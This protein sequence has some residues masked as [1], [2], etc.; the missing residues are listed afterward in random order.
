LGEGQ[1]EALFVGGQL[2]DTE[3]AVVMG[4]TFVEL[5]WGQA[6]EEWGEDGASFVPKVENRWLAV[7]HPRKDGAE[8]KSKNDR[9]TRNRRFYRA[10]TVV[11]K[12][13]TGH[14]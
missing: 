5:V 10:E 11:M 7:E 13:L 4:D 6:V 8:L 14:F 1:H 3:V 9:T 12:T 2:A